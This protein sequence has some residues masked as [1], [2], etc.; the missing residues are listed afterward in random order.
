MVHHNTFV[1]EIDNAIQHAKYNHLSVALMMIKE[2][3]N[4]EKIYLLGLRVG[5]TLCLLG[6]KK[7]STI[8][9]IIAWAP[10]FDVREYLIY[11]P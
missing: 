6:Y 7:F 1:M 11:I 8:S 4:P 10:D 5:G 2:K 9:G 3:V